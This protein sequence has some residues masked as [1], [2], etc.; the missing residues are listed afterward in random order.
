MI[1]NYLCHFQGKT[2]V[3]IDLVAQAL[4]EHSQ[5]LY[6]DMKMLEPVIK[7]L[8]ENANMESQY[9]IDL[10]FDKDVK[11]MFEIGKVVLNAV[12]ECNS[13]NYVKKD[14]SLPVDATGF[15]F[16]KIKLDVAAAL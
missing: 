3:P 10:R 12:K 9:C 1:T 5:L 13:D 2:S 15:N 4:A 8:T 6:K 14:F 11:L 7:I 16:N